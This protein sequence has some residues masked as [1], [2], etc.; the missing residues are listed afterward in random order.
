MNLTNSKINQTHNQVFLTDGGIETTLIFHEGFELP[1][2]AAFDLLRT[3]KG[4]NALR[5]YF[6][7]Y[8]ALAVNS[9]TG[10]IL[11]SPTWRASSDW[12]AK[13]GYNRE[14]LAR[15]NRDA[16]YLLHEIRDEYAVH[17]S[18]FL[19]SG[20]IG[21][22]GD[23]YQVSNAMSSEES[24]VY[25]SEQIETFSQ[26]SVDM[27]TAITMTYPA[28][29]IG[30]VRAAQAFDLPVVISFTTE[31][32]GHLPD[33]TSL[34][35]AIESVDRETGNGPAYYMINCAHPDHF[36]KGLEE[37]ASWVRRIQGVRANASRKS[38]AELD[39]AE[40]LDSGNPDELAQQYQKLRI[41]F[42]QFNILGG[43]CGTDHRHLGS[44]SRYC[45]H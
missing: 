29:A 38:H 39:E 33:G 18:P 21:P 45:C 23:G 35:D 32:D 6:E 31:T 7:R 22:R 10:F 20:C 30:I 3:K 26:C 17:T 40:E 2:F 41:Q 25:H 14:Q 42:P 15:A 19:I 27:V 4:R 5:Q 28:E 13:L 43:C 34:K 12:A 16:I 8:A 44:I 36:R 9:R 1:Y 11:E 24:Q 37:N